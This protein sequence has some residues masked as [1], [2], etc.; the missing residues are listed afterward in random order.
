[1]PAVFI[2]LFPDIEYPNPDWLAV[3]GG[4]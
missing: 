3:V 2:S 1:V 4:Q